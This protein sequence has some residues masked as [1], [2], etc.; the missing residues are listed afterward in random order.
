MSSGVGHPDVNLLLVPLDSRPGRWRSNPR[1]P[2]PG[3]LPKNVRLRRLPVAQWDDFIILQDLYFAIEALDLVDQL[4][5]KVFHAVQRERRR[6][7]TEDQIGEFVASHGVDRNR[8]MATLNSDAVAAKSQ[9]S[10]QLAMRY[11]VSR[12]PTFVV[13]D[14]WK[15]DL[16]RAGSPSKAL[17]V[18]HFLVHIGK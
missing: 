6:L 8:F 17:G 5:P 12:T 4:H 11:D 7:E 13:G 9:E 3:S 1:G 14:R 10:T 2:E 16:A 18:L 15:T